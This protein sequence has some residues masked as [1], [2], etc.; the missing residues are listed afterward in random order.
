MRWM[1][2]PLDLK[3]LFGKF[4]DTVGPQRIIF[5]TDSS[6]FPR[7]FA[8]RYLEVQFQVCSE[9]GL[10][11]HDLRVIFAENAARLLGMSL[12]DPDHAR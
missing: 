5:G 11:E 2:Y 1:P 6:W 8:R 12:P 10:A 4:L 9:L 3:T 7:G